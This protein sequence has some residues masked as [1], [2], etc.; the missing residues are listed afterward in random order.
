M[1]ET[2]A[3]LAGRVV[4]TDFEGW[5]DWLRA[6]FQ[7]NA[8]NFQIGQRLLSE[9]DRVKVWQI[10]LA[11][12]ERVP[13]HRHVLDY[14]WTAVTPGRGEQHVDDGTTREVSYYAGETRHLVFPA[15]RYL[16][17]DLRNTGTEP[18]IFVTVEHK[19]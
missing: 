15:E 10:R 12:G 17:H 14:F 11:P 8:Y 4:G 7:A 16:L 13:A 2:A 19:R 9:T 18:L 3:E 6:E 5:P 1:S